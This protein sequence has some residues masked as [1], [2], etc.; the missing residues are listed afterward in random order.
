MSE[1]PVNWRI[2]DLGV[3]NAIPCAGL[4]LWR[5][6]YLTQR[7]ITDTL[8]TPVRAVFQPDI[9]EELCEYTQELAR[10]ERQTVPVSDH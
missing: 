6:H 10:V 2:K 1:T 8:L 7:C 9:Q 3:I 5:P 4:G